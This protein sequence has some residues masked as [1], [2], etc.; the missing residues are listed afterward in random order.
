[1]KDI[2]LKL[3]NKREENG[4]SIDEVAEDLKVSVR[5][6]ENLEEGSRDNFKDITVL[7]AL[8]QD[9]AKYLGFDSEKMLD[10]FNEYVFDQTSRIS[11]EDIKKAKELKIENEKEKISSPY[12]IEKKEKGLRPLI[13]GGIVFTLVVVF[14]VSYFVVSRIIE[15][16]R[17][18]SNVSY[19]I[20]GE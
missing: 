19:K 11:L 2:G 15:Q 5:A 20:G 16:D 13:I 12:T 7:K 18:D 6:I 14:C 17:N 8:I 10:E 9:Y 4:L 3:K 1:M